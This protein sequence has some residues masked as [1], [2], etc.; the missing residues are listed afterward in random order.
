M[1]ASVSTASRSWLSSLGGTRQESQQSLPDAQNGRRLSEVLADHIDEGHPFPLD[2]V[3]VHE[4]EAGV[5][6]LS[7]GLEHDPQR[8]VHKKPLRIS[9]SLRFWLVA[10]D[11]PVGIPL[12]LREEAHQLHPAPQVI[13]VPRVVG[14]GY[15]FWECRVFPQAVQSGLVDVHDDGNY[16]V[17]ALIGQ[18]RIDLCKE[19]RLL[20]GFST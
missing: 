13:H 3:R 15:V 14:K 16:A 11:R 6:R 8:T 1:V 7:G 19:G 20:V 5:R 17:C 9:K 2:S 4:F 10:L 18:I 12:R